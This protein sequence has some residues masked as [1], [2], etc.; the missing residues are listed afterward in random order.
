MDIKKK[1]RKSGTQKTGGRKA[2]TPNKIDKS[3]RARIS[4]FL[5]ANFDQAVESWRGIT[6]PIQKVK[7]YTDLIK[8][9]VPTLQSVD[10]EARVN[11][12]EPIEDR[13][14]ALDTEN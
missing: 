7:L 3:L 4:D 11:K 12:S 9:A 8:F 1:G 14:R 13:M 6:E 10:L 5:D 2:G